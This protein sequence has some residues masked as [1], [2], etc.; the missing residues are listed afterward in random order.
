MPSRQTVTIGKEAMKKLRQFCVD[1]EVRPNDVIEA[2]ILREDFE[3]NGGNLLVLIK[4]NAKNA[5]E[6]C[7]NA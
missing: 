1:T 5:K 6:A 3:K 4:N 2:M 7:E